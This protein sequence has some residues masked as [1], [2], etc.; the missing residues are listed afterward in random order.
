MEMK[1]MF[2]HECD[3]YVQPQIKHKIIKIEDGGYVDEE[4][5]CPKCNT[6]LEDGI[7]GALLGW[8]S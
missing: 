7:L 1:V 3:K 2:C 5:C 6:R 4:M 8:Q